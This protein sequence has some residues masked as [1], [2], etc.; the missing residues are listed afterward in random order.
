VESIPIYF[1]TTGI[2]GINVRLFNP[3][4]WGYWNSE[5]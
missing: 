2:M 4:N 3:R 5:C 1:P